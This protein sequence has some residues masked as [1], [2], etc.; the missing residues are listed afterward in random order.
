MVL[1]ISVGIAVDDGEILRSAARALPGGGLFLL[2]ATVGVLVFAAGLGAGLAAFATGLAA[3]A[4]GP[5]SGAGTTGVMTQLFQK[6]APPPCWGRPG[7]PFALAG[8]AGAPS[9]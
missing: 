4:C 9:A 8:A 3:V 2:V 1:V 7:L 5:R 6:Q